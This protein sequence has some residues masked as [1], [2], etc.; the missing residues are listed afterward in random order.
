MTD[1]RFLRA[2]R[3]QA[4]DSTPVWLMRQAGR[5]LPEYRALRER[6]SLLELCQHPELAAEVTLQPLRRFSLDA[7]IVFADILLP[8]LALGIEVTF[9]VG[10]G[11]VI[12]QPLR[13]PARVSRFP[14]PDETALVPVAEAIRI[15]RGELPREIALMGFA[16]APFTLASYLIEGGSSRQF[17]A[18]K[19]FLLTH[20]TEWELLLDTLTDLTIRYLRLQVAAGANAVQLFDSWAGALAPVLYRE[21]VL[22][23]T[24]RIVQEIRSLGV[25]V[26]V[27]STGTAGFLDLVA[28]TGAD[29]IGVDWRVE[30]DRAW[31]LI[32]D[33]AIQGNL[34][35]AWLLA[36]RSDLERAVRDVLRRAGGRPGHIFNLGHG[37]LPETPPDA[38]AYLVELVHEWPLVPQD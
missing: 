38:V 11:P 37:V 2:C 25:P 23:W 30:L 28:E 9:A 32:G 36:P 33:R 31:Q 20:R 21:A 17:L 29:V 3:R 34:D 16:G 13:D 27:F 10:D 35:P 18:T 22:P 7:A 4:T 1:S 26:I 8:L 19:R 15:V 12:G 5:Y 14:D 24:Q 6:Y